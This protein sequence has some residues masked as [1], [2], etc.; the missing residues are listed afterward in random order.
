MHG[1]YSTILVWQ[2]VYDESVPPHVIY[3][4]PVEAWGK[5]KIKYIFFS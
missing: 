3:Q 5:S 1:P 2:L 4:N